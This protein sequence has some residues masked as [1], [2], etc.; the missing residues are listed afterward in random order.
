MYTDKTK[1]R[2]RAMY[3]RNPIVARASRFPREST[4]GIMRATEQEKSIERERAI[5]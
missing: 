5:Q 4:I 3:K 1:Y 2:E